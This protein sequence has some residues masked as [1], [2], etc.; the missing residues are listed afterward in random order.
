MA[1]RLAIVIVLVAFVAPAAARAATLKA[2]YRFAGTYAS[3][4]AGAPTLTPLGPGADTFATETVKI[5]QNARE[6][7]VTELGLVVPSTAIRSCTAAR[8]AA[9]RPLAAKVLGLLH[10]TARGSFRTRGRFSAA[11]VRGT[12]WDTVDRCDGTLTRVYAGVVVVT[13][14]RRHRQVVVRAGHSYL[15][16]AG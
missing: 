6:R 1:R 2:D 9:A 11:T 12:R 10:A 5:L 13:D 15:A 4:V 14:V 8:I 16:P 7:G 3:S